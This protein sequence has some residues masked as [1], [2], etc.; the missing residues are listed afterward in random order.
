MV[1][2]DLICVPP[3]MSGEQALA[4]QIGGC[5]P[6]ARSAV[7]RPTTQR[8]TKTRSLADS[9]SRNRSDGRLGRRE[10]LLTGETGAGRPRVRE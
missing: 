6:S 7:P 10:A 3:L 8:E 4:A 1:H 2:A 9:G 5:V